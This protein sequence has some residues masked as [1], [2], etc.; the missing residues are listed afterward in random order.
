VIPHSHEPEKYKIGLSSLN[1]LSNPAYPVFE[2]RSAHPNCPGGVRHWI[3]FT[4]VDMCISLNHA[5]VVQG[6]QSSFMAR[7]GSM[8]QY[9][10]QGPCIR[11]YVR[12]LFS[13]RV[14][15]IWSKKFKQIQRIY[16]FDQ[17]WSIF[18][19]IDKWKSLSIRVVFSL[20]LFITKRTPSIDS[21]DMTS[22]GTSW[23]LTDLTPQLGFVA[24]CP[25]VALTAQVL[26]A[27][28]SSCSAIQLDGILPG[29]G[30]L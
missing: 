17:F 24:G 18:I 21:I 11:W 12:C 22:P 6:I 5:S 3:A 30:S 28:R 7:A 14:P 4:V 10:F 19:N 27:D 15:E 8:A 29:F 1:R 20:Y 23:N 13:S 9:R 25:C 26:V 16:N 2:S